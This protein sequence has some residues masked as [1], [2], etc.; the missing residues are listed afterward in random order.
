MNIT[1][2]SDLTLEEVTEAAQLI[3]EAVS[4]KADI[5]FGTA[6]RDG[7]EHVR[8]TVIATGF[9]AT[10]GTEEEEGAQIT[11]ET[12]LVKL[13]QES[14]IGPDDWDIPTFL[15]RSRRSREEPEPRPWGHPDR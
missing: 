4:D 14:R 9:A 8:L 5:I 6:I 15:R 10:V 12:M 1:G 2:G 3:R 13:Q 7:M 11:N